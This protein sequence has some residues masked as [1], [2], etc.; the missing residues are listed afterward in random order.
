MAAAHDC[1]LFKK[2]RACVIDGKWS[3]QTAVCN[4]RISGV[5]WDADL[6]LGYFRGCEARRHPGSKYCRRHSQSRLPPEATRIAGHREVAAEQGV[7]LQYKV[8]N[9]WVAAAAV[10]LEQARAY[11]L[12]LL[13]PQTRASLLADPDS[14]PALASSFLLVSCVAGHKDD[15]KGIPETAITRKSNGIL[16]A[17]SPCLQILAI[18][19]TYASE[20]VTQV[21]F[22]A[23]HLLALFSTLA[24]IIYD[25]ACGAARTVA[26]KLRD[27]NTSGPQRVAWERLAALH[28]VVD[29]LHL[30]YHSACRDASSGWFVLVWTQ[31]I[32]QSCVGSIRRLPSKSFTLLA[33]GSWFCLMQRRRIKKSSCSFSPTLT[34]FATPVIKPQ[35]ATW[36]RSMLPLQ[37]SLPARH[38]LRQLLLSS[39]WCLASP[40][41]E[42]EEAN[43]CC[44]GGQASATPASPP[45]CPAPL[46]WSL[47]PPRPRTKWWSTP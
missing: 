13:R 9:A 47:R 26:R 29:R 19:P 44:E 2:V 30:R 25:N 22:L 23:Q 12:T 11:V 20:S 6:R 14:C 39:Y 38:Q 40:P 43:P 37:R 42:A 27:P 32:M 18:R 33:V 4:D 36:L 41:T 10:P 5:T 28:W 17:V 7:E 1:D 31:L 3:V 8:D 35:T 34:I 16:V 45:P 15:R 46:P 21:L 24:Y